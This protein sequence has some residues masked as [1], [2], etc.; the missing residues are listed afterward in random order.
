MNFFLGIIMSI[1][2]VCFFLCSSAFA[3]SSQ[4]GGEIY[5]KPED[6]IKF[7][8]KVEKTMAAKGARA[9]I[10]ARV[11]RPRDQLPEGIGFTHTAIAVYSQITMADGRKLPGYAIY[12][13]Y[14]RE[15]EPNIS[16]LVVDYPVDFFSGVQVL[17][18]G[19]IIPSPDLQQKLIETIASPAYKKV[20]NP[21]YSVIA[22]PFTLDYQN[23]TEHTLDVIVSAIYNTDDIRKIK[24]NEKAYFK[25]QPVQINPV[26]LAL[27][28]MFVA[29]V[30]TSD[31]PGDTV[32]ATFETIGNFL[33]KYKAASE[34]ITVQ[35]DAR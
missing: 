15:K 23:C 31:H 19:L 14:Q 8:K 26:K 25:P 7:S 34:V 12:N 5:F 3:G 17:E 33:T 21:K 35:P 11:G 30:T 32:T 22:N 18:A 2:S 13:L 24:A 10:I 16:D 29:D 28:T 20:H 4:T 27:G 1:M 9:A 6:I